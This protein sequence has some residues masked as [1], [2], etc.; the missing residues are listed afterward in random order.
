MDVGF[1]LEVDVWLEVSDPSLCYKPFS[2]LEF[3][4]LG[5]FAEQG[6]LNSELKALKQPKGVQFS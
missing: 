6:T 1:W 5:G 2:R 3:G 4:I